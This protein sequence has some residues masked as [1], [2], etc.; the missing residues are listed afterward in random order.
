MSA[1]LEV[2]SLPRAARPLAGQLSVAFTPAT[3]GR[4]LVLLVGAILAPGRRTVAACLWAARAVAAG[5]KAGDASS[6]HRVFSHAAWA[7]WPL[8]KV[9]AAAALTHVPP[10]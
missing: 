3:F 5:K 10:G 4:V 6:Y 1:I 8:G 7:L 2:S 9:L